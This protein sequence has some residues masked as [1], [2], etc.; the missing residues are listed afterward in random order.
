MVVQIKA[1]TRNDVRA[2]GSIHSVDAALREFHSA[3]HLSHQSGA[4][5]RVCGCLKMS[6]QLFPPSYF[7]FRISGF[8][9][10]VSGSGFRVPGLGV[11]LGSAGI[12]V[13][14][15]HDRVRIDRAHTSAAQ[16]APLHRSTR[17]ASRKTRTRWGS[18]T[19]NTHRFAG[20]KKTLDLSRSP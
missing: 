20:S 7:G 13:E 16:H 15:G 14:R 19:T 3:V 6:V 1:I 9:F 2:G 8:G 10:R 18:F 4:Y 12:S 5:Q 17:E 11:C